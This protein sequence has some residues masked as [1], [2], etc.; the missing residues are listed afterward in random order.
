MEKGE[1]VLLGLREYIPIV[2]KELVGNAHK[3]Q[4]KCITRK[5]TSQG[6]KHP[7]NIRS[8]QEDLEPI[9]I[10]TRGAK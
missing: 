7:T 10:S 3:V 5:I 9:V 2:L 6:P 4:D 8:G 1:S